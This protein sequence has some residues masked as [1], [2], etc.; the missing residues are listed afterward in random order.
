MPIVVTPT[1][2]DIQTV[3]RTVLLGVLP[4]G[5]D[6]V[7]GQINRV[8]EPQAENYAVMWPTNT[9]RLS[10]NLR[11]YA[12]AKCIASIAGD[13]LTVSE[14]DF[15]TIGVG[16]QVFGEGVTEGTII[17]AQTSGP[18][19]GVG[20]YTIAPAPQNVGAEVMA[21]GVFNVTQPQQ[22][23]VQIDVH[24]PNSV[25]N[26]G[27][28]TTML[29][30]DYAVEAFAAINPAVSPLFAEDPVQMPF[31]NDQ[32]QYEWRWIV[33]AALQVNQTVH[34]IPQQFA[35]EAVVGLIDV[36]AAYGEHSVPDE[37]PALPLHARLASE[38]D[39]ITAGSSGP[40]WSQ[41]AI[42]ANGGR[43]FH[44]MGWN[45][46]VGGTTTAQMLVR[47]S[48]VTALLPRVVTFLGG[49]NDLT[50]TSDTPEQIAAN[51]RACINAYRSVGARTV[52]CKV[53]PRSDSVWLGAGREAD[54][55]ALNDLIAGMAARDVKVVDLEQSFDPAT[56]TKEGLH[57]N[58]LGARVLGEGF[59]AALGEWTEA[60]DVLELYR[61][62]SNIMVAAGSNPEL[63]GTGGGKSGVTGD[64]ADHWT[65][66][67][68]APGV[69][70]T[71]SKITLPDGTAAQRFVLSGTNSIDGR[72]VNFRRASAYSG[73]AGEQYEA[74]VG[75]SLAPA[76][77]NVQGIYL[78]IDTGQSPNSA[79]SSIMTI[80]DALSGVL[81]V[82]ADELPSNDASMNAQCVIKLA[83]GPVS[84]DV[85]WF[86]PYVRKVPAG[87]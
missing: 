6:I 77:Q 80:D 26:A 82:P 65:A 67:A 40:E 24:G 35:D 87:Q 29:R 11:D 34:N 86:K 57:P 58:Y 4:S 81:R 41:F 66:E 8:A 61:D 20:T 27:A 12:D 76:A 85:T 43:L 78:S 19:G 25:A 2:D 59:A 68:N 13:V 18:S 16:N 71:A 69:V 14:I 31:V 3:L 32:N 37:I 79:E 49:T 10:T 30:D 36:D 53:L 51:I 52:L 47:V 62:P 83:A 60:G 72:V 84:A 70:V 55:L 45:N 48:A 75:F 74:W 42:V 23:T 7:E 28:I 15:G 56:M 21:M 39:S 9:M 1:Q 50:G 33:K 17:S 63:V 5:F 64:V 54:R 46:A 22:F 44:P 73:V 38:G